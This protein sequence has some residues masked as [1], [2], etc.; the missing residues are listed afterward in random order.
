MT[1][2]RGA[3]R[4]LTACGALAL[5][6]LARGEQGARTQITVGEGPER[7]ARFAS[8]GMVYVEALVE[9]RWIG[10]SWS[11][12]GRSEPSTMHRPEPA[13]HIEIKV[14]GFE[15]KTHYQV[16][17]SIDGNTIGWQLVESPTLAR[18]AW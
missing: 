14:A 16:R 8:G 1:R 7:Q 3:L 9:G 18:C 2:V 13:F 5:A 4:L 11:A 12:Q 15:I 10:R 17:Y 6:P